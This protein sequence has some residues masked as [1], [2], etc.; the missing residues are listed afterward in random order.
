M[1]D[2]IGLLCGFVKAVSYAAIMHVPFRSDSGNFCFHQLFNYAR[3]EWRTEA[4]RSQLLP[5]QQKVL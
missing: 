1:I 3:R 2:K 5:K 4:N